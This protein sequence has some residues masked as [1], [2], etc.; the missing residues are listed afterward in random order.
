LRVGRE[1][2]LWGETFWI[3][4]VVLILSGLVGLKSG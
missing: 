1:V 3:L 4:D 2:L